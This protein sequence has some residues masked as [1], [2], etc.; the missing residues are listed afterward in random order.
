M[1][2]SY[3]LIGSVILDMPQS[4]EKKWMEVQNAAS[5]G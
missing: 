2:L 1:V 5:S 3:T 4:R